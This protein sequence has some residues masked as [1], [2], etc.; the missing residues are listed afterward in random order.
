M[1]LLFSVSFILIAPFCFRS[2]FFW[3]QSK[4]YSYCDGGVA[5]L[6]TTINIHMLKIRCR[7]YFSFIL[8]LYWL[9]ERNEEQSHFACHIFQVSKFIFTVMNLNGM[10]HK[11][12]N[13]IW[14]SEIM[15]MSSNATFKCGMTRNISKKTIYVKCFDSK[16]FSCKAS[17]PSLPIF[18]WKKN[19]GQ[20]GSFFH[21][22][23]QQ[24][25]DEVPN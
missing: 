7:Y 18:E 4:T 1:L 10:K 16:P 25:V 14:L 17:L 6:D 15:K 20:I 19:A 3:F 5:A 11:F 13:Q 12:S 9:L 21:V 22:N 24:N 23:E 2:F 8:F